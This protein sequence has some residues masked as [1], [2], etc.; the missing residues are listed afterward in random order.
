MTQ[1]TE[2]PIFDADQHMYETSEALTKHLPERYRKA[3]QF[4]Q[5]GKRTRIAIMGQITEYIPNPTF[6]RVAAPGAHE[7][8]YAARNTEGLTMR[9][10]TG[11]PIERAGSCATRWTASGSWI[12]RA[13]G[14]RWSTPRWP[15]SSSTPRP[16]IRS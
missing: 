12:A 10:M 11:V 8:F 3:V 14:S 1:F 2:A 7:K 6:E 16:S 5:I 9:E 15:T 4:V 13:C